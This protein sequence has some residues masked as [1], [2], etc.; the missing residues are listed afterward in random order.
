M[1]E[2]IADSVNLPYVI[3]N[4]MAPDNFENLGLV[5]KDGEG[6][7]QTATTSNAGTTNPQQKR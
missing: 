2:R 7:E 5:F 3:R 1:L 4:L 6:K